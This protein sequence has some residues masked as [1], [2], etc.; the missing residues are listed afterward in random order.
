MS[1]NQSWNSSGSEEDP[2]TESGPPVERCGVLSKVSS[3]RGRGPA[4]RAHLPRGKARRAARDLGWG[5][6]EDS[7]CPGAGAAECAGVRGRKVRLE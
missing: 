1:D 4:A 6:T 7:H 2:E 3:V 5:W